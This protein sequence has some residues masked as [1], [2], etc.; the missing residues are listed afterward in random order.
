MVVMLPSTFGMPSTGDSRT[1]AGRPAAEAGVTVTS[2]MFSC[3]LS[4][5]DGTANQLCRSLTSQ[6]APYGEPVKRLS[7]A[8]RSP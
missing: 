1:L 2:T 8:I 7:S 5:E 6:P 3:T 4:A